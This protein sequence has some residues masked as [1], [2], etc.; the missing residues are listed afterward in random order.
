MEGII[1]YGRKGHGSKKT[2]RTNRWT[3]W[4]KLWWQDFTKYQDNSWEP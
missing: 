4:G 2:D 3:L 1:L